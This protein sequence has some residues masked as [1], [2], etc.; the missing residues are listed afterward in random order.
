VVFNVVLFFTLP[1]WRIPWPY[2]LVNNQ[3]PEYGLRYL[4]RYGHWKHVRKIIIDSGVEIFRNPNVKEY[5]GGP[6]THIHRQYLLYLRI[7]KIVPKAE[8]Y[9]VV[10]DYCD[11]YN[12]GNLWVNG[13][14]NIERTVENILYATEKYN[15]EWLIPIQGHYMKPRTVLKCLELLKEHGFEFEK[16]DYYAVAPT[17]IIPYEHILKHTVMYVWRWF[18][19]NLGYVPRLHVFG[20]KLPALKYIR[21]YIYSFDTMAWTRPVELGLHKKYPYSAK[22][23]RQRELFFL[24]YVENLRKKYGVE[25]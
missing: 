18:K 25:V 21:N 7:K 24:K 14:T 3:H 13:R 4:L 8:V 23:E 2:I 5:P 1:P 6:K 19:D 17:C 9:V 15:V 20:P 10:P 16:H 12:P 11:D 22:N